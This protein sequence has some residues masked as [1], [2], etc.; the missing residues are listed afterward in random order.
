MELAPFGIVGLETAFPLLYTNL[1]EKNICTL[2]F[3]VDRLTKVPASVF[4]LP[5]GEL[6]VG[7]P[8]DLA[9]FDLEA[10]VQIEKEQFES[11]GKNTPFNGWKCKGWTVLTMVDGKIVYE[12]ETARV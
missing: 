1:V 11:K 8:A 4:K 10:E 12:K 6:E 2:E 3:L 5:Y 7:K 9:V